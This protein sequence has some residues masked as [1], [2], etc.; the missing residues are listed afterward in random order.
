MPG[1]IPRISGQARGYIRHATCVISKKVFR[2][3]VRR[4]TII[5]YF[6]CRLNQK[7]FI[8]FETFFF[9]LGFLRSVSS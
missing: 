9:F 7:S 5:R 6:T 1:E 8:C 4:G 3:V 2:A